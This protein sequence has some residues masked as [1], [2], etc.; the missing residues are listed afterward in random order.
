MDNLIKKKNRKRMIPLFA[1]KSPQPNRKGEPS[2]TS[3]H[4]TTIH[5]ISIFV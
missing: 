5:L 2:R 4:K 1:S 3:E